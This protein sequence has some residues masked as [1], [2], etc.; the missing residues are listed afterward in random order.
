M[1]LLILT[2]KINCQD[3]ILGFMHGW[4][5]ELAKHFEK[6]I[7]IALGVGEHH[8]PANVK[9]L[10]LGK[11]GGKS[12]IK[13]LVRFYKYIWQ[14]RQNYDAVF[15]HMNQ[16]YILLGSF[17]WQLW[18]KKI[19][20]WRNHPKGGFL[21]RAAVYLSNIVFCTSKFAF[22]ARFKKTRIMPV[23]VDTDFF[24]S[25]SAAERIKN[26]ILFFSRISPIKKPDIFIQALAL[27][28]K[29][30]VDFSGKIVGNAPERDRACLEEIKKEIINNSLSDSLQ[31]EKGVPNNQAP[32]IFNSFD[33]YI[34]LTPTGSLDKTIFEA[35]ACATMVL[36]SNE[37]L[38]GEV[39]E[40]LFFDGTPA[41]LA[42]KIKNIFNMG[43]Q[44]KQQL[45]ASSRDFVIKNHSLRVLAA[46][47]EEA[48]G[49]DKK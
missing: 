28:K 48:L 47:L 31:I 20:L 38:A 44:E 25:D 43:E 39:D 16:E 12:W 26:S 22:V 4:V 9:V 23:G 36:M 1:K 29:E 41:D 19:T 14:E 30:N 27:L 10:S 5:A 21:A 17:L 42:A 49:K 2:Q 32:K 7:V 24:K 15:V 6:I 18:G 37:T 34:N 33:L 45:L 35:M 11:E 8:L 3:D 40:R 46:K 13:Y